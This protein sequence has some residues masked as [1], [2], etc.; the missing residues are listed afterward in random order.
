MLLPRT[1]APWNINQPAARFHPERY[2]RIVNL[3]NE[4]VRA[5]LYVL[6]TEQKSLKLR[7]N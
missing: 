2:Y 5:V 7:Q 3:G 4:S 6:K 1:S